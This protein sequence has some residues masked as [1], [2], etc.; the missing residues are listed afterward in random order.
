MYFRSLLVFS[1]GT[2]K[3]KELHGTTC[4]SALSG[5]WALQNDGITLQGYKLKFSCNLDGQIY[6]AFVLLIHETL[7]ED[8]AHREM[9]LYLLDKTVKAYT[10]PCGS[11]ALSSEQVSIRNSFSY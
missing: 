7:D 1:E 6:A 9:D 3:R 4:V 8:V 2:T 5:R 11:V 10:T